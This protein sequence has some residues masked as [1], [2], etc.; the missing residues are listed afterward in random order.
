MLRDL[1]EQKEITK[2]SWVPTD[3][4]IADTLT[5]QGASDRLLVEVINNQNLRFDVTSGSFK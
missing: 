5:K 2:F 3:V 4:Q 1:I